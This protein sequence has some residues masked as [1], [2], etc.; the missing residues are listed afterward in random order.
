MVSSVE[1]AS[2]KVLKKGLTLARVKMR[3]TSVLVTRLSTIPASCTYTEGKM[4]SI[5]ISYLIR[6]CMIP[7][8]CSGEEEEETYGRGSA[9]DMLLSTYLA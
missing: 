6:L 4:G 7:V 3:S 8:R 5:C 2:N 1:Q 9:R